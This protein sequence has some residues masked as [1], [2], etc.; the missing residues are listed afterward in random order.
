MNAAY[1]LPLK[2]NI[3]IETVREMRAYEANLV[4]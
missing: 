4:S 3:E 1:Y 2:N